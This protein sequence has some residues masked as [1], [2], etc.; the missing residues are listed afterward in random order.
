[1]P[2]DASI[3]HQYLT[4][5]GLRAH[6]I[7]AGDSHAQPV[8]LL[9][10]GGTDSA[11]LSWDP[12]I[13]ALAPGFRVFA[14]DLPGYGE[15]A[16]PS[17]DCTMAF[18]IDVLNDLLEALELDRV[19]LVGISMG[20]GIAIGY[21][22]E[23]PQRVARLVAV[24]SYG[25]QRQAPGGR[26]GYYLVRWD[27]LNRLSWALMARSR[28]LVRASL[29]QLF[30]NPQVVDE[31]LVNAVM[32]E[33]RR[34]NAGYAWRSFQRSEVLPGGLRTLYLDRL[35]E[36]RVPTL[37]IHGA[38]DRLVPLACAQEA[39]RLLPGSRLVI[40]PGCGHWPQREN[41]QAFNEVLLGFL[42]LSVD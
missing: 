15:S 14:P 31:A 18:Y 20:G 38:Q 13:P 34:P 4:F 32:E 26:W 25:L 10:G 17:V 22:L 5:K 42:R 1:M 21:T 37:F 33:V 7:V 27:W 40:L 23:H 8:V 11:R 16:C 3:H 28:A 24:D 39:H 41:P 36:I 19:T 2:Q 29:Q 12:V 9:H 30:A 35:G 6:I